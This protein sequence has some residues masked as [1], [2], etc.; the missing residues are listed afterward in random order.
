MAADR[1][2]AAHLLGLLKASP[3]LFCDETRCPVLDP[4][5]CKTKTGFLWAIARDDRSR[6]ARRRARPH[7]R[8]PDA[9]E[10][11]IEECQL[12]LDAHRTRR[13][14]IANQLR[15][16]RRT[17]SSVAWA[18][19][20]SFAGASFAATATLGPVNLPTSAQ[21]AQAMLRLR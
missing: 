8:S 11:R 16:V 7:S 3:K 10:D 2:Y 15:L 21:F 4:G 5:R 6:L 13:L 1:Y 14:G 17:R 18:W 19:P 9:T 20:P 12:D